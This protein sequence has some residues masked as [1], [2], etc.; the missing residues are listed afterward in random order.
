MSD[1]K[2]EMIFYVMEADHLD[3]LK[4]VAKRLY[5]EN[6]MNGDEMRDAAHSIMT[7]VWYA[8]ALSALRGANA[9]AV[10]VHLNPYEPFYECSQHGRSPE[11]CCTRA[12]Q[13]E[14]P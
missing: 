9:E 13:P 6:R 3:T 2:G 5:T 1:E 8:E 4:S 10:Y 7:I 11:W 12:T 14:K